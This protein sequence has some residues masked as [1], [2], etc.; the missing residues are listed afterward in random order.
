MLRRASIISRAP[1][2]LVLCV[3]AE[4][5]V[6]FMASSGTDRQGDSIISCLGLVEERPTSRPRC[7]RCSVSESCGPGW[8]IAHFLCNNSNDEYER[9]PKKKRKKARRERERG[10]PDEREE[11]EGREGPSST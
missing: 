11:E 10:E 2:V 9:R 3:G 1:T 8:K 4:V 7:C 5:L 6:S